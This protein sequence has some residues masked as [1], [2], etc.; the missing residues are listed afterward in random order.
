MKRSFIVFNPDDMY[1][2]LKKEN[3]V[4]A[5]A[6]TREDVEQCQELLKNRYGHGY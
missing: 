5:K 6:K 1:W 2:E 4:V 3:K